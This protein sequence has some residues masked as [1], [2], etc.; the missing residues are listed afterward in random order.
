MMVLQ[1]LPHRPDLLRRASCKQH[2][3]RVIAKRQDWRNNNLRVQSPFCTKLV[4]VLAAAKP[5]A[6]AGAIEER[7]LRA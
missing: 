7:Y 4:I 6:E 2:R 3:R 5:A 1:S